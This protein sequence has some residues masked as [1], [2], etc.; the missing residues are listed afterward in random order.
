[1]DFW[2]SD[3]GLP[4]RII[5][6]HSEQRNLN[7]L[8]GFQLECA[9]KYSQS[10]FEEVSELFNTLPIGH[11][12]NRR[13]LVVHGGLFGDSRMTIK[14]FQSVNRL[15]QP[16]ADGP[17]HDVLWS[18]P[19]DERGRA[20]SP[21][22]GTITFGP[23]VTEKFLRANHLELLVRSHQ[24]QQ[25]GYAIQHAG[26]CITVFSAPNYVGE[27]DNKG[28]VCTISF[29]PDGSIVLPLGFTQFNP[30]PIPEKYRPMRFASPGLLC[31]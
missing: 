18:D 29:K 13:I 23:D 14:K 22:G 15:C 25:S 20:P 5:L 2:Q 26:K 11:I 24:V 10:I 17:F 4:I 9:T 28:A 6:I 21:R 8:Y 1:L 12:L 19:M 7:E 31:S 3:L 30:Q 16:P 27:M